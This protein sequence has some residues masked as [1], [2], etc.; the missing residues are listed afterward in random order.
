M[1][2]RTGVSERLL[3]YYEEQGLLRPT[4][5]PIAQI[6]P[7]VRAEGADLV[8]LCSDL[9]T[10]LRRERQRITTAIDDLETSRSL[11]D[12]VLT[13]APA[14]APTWT[15]DPAPTGRPTPDPRHRRQTDARTAA[16]PRA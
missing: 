13:R 8:P 11:L 1:V 2:R 3:R 7:C 15:V 6:L 10:R 4:R 9:V 16:E 14:D 5:L 12:A